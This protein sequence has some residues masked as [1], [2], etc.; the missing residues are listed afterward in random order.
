MWVDKSWPAVARVLAVRCIWPLA[1]APDLQHRPD[2]RFAL[3]RDWH[4][5]SSQ[6]LPLCSEAIQSW[7]TD[8]AAEE[9]PS[10]GRSDATQAYSLPAPSRLG[11]IN[12]HAIGAT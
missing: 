7:Q 12:V 1:L 8:M 6:T 4:H 2:L 11:A 3:V 10:R 5:D 9:A